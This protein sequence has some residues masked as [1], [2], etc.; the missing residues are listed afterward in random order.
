MLFVLI[1]KFIID[2]SYYSWWLK[3]GQMWGLFGKQPTYTFR[4]PPRST[5]PL[6][7]IPPDPFNLLPEY[8]YYLHTS[9]VLAVKSLHELYHSQLFCWDLI[10]R[11]RWKMWIV[12]KEGVSVQGI[13]SWCVGMLLY[14]LL[15]LISALKAEHSISV[16]DCKLLNNIPLFDSTLTTTI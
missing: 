3:V 14:E 15:G 4:D 13:F 9:Y 10:A 1:N 16:S 6:H 2:L 11:V 5:P 8:F 7:P 12:W